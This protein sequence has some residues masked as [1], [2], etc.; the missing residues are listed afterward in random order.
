MCTLI[1]GSE[2]SKYF[3]IPDENK[4]IFQEKM[5]DHVFAE[6]IRKLREAESIRKGLE[7]S[8]ED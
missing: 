6:K 2:A 7:N 8:K 4:K 5:K 3:K 1:K